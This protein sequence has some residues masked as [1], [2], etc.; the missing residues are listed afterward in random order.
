[1]FEFSLPVIIE[2]Y[3]GRKGCADMAPATLCACQ[4]STKDAHLGG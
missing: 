2:T 3:D 4:L 1:M